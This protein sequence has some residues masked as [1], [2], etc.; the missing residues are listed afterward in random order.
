MPWDLN[1]L[2]PYI[3]IFRICPTYAGSA[4]VVMFFHL[5]LSSACSG[6]LTRFRHEDNIF[7]VEHCMGNCTTAVG[8][9][10]HATSSTSNS[11]TNEFQ[12]APGIPGRL[13]V[14]LDHGQFCVNQHEKACGA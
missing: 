9:L 1:G 7:G 13:R 11:Y 12:E 10:S 5:Q 6:C 2:C 14:A 8:C 4:A 3:Y